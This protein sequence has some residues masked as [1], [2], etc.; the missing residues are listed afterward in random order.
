MSLT[1]GYKVKVSKD[2][3]LTKEGIPASLPFEIP[4]KAG[5]NIMGYPMTR[6][7]DGKA[8]VQ[9]L[10]DRRTLIKVQDE[11]GK[12]IEDL[13]FF[14]GWQNNIG[15]FKPGEGYKIKVT[16][17]DVLTFSADP[18]LGW[19][20]G[21]PWVDPRDGNDY[22]TVKIGNQVWMAEN[23]A[24]LPSVNPPAGGSDTEPYYYVYGYSGIEVTAAK[25]TTNYSSYGVLYNWPSALIA[26]PAGWHLPG[27][28][29]W[30]Q[31]EIALGMTQAQ[32]D[33]TGNRGT[34]QGAQM[35]YT[36]GWNG[37][38][39][40]T[41]SSGFSGL[42]GGCRLPPTYGFMNL[43]GLGLWWSSTESSLT[44][45]WDRILY[46]Y[47]TLVDRNPNS[48]EDGFSVRCVRD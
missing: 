16:A 8:V 11:T 14:G 10:I 12:A 28:A 27:D 34:D 38:G 46:S 21:D 5:W 24:W 22:K 6:E 37:N 2:C 25:A 17:D 7:L 18:N 32:A 3:Q 41:N 1:E 42:P 26:C 36:S 48:K 39:N 47:N 33:A 19:Q 43:G 31:M 29:E 9:Q 20:P 35:K 23:L 15:K 13:G 40:G 44:G 30:K 4:L 45:A